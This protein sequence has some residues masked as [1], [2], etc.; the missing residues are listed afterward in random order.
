MKA[1]R[2]IRYCLVIGNCS[3]AVPIVVSGKNLNS[4]RSHVHGVNIN[5][6]ISNA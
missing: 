2:G 6:S 3:E 5:I 4:L 1:D